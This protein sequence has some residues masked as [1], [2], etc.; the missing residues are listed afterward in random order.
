MTLLLLSGS[1][2]AF[3]QGSSSLQ[4]LMRHRAIW[5]YY[6]PPDPIGSIRILTWLI[7]MSIRG[8][9]TLMQMGSLCS[10][11]FTDTMSL[12]AWE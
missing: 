7:F 4:K 11:N 6:T 3:Q 2:L 5:I 10:A 12:S 9:E 8:I 1:P